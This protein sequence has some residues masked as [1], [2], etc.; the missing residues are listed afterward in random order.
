MSKSWIVATGILG[1]LG[2]MIGAYGAHGLEGMLQRSGND[3]DWVNKRLDQCE[4]AVRYHL[5]HT[6]ALLALS[7][8]PLGGYWWSKWTASFWLLGILLF[9]GGLYSIVFF[10]KLGHWAIVPLG[11]LSLIVGWLGLILLGLTGSK[12]AS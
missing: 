5:L 10:D 12:Q 6:V 4:T 2:V 11:G 7:L 1:M 8:S 9:C 3:L